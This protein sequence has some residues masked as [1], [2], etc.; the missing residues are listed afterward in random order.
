MHAST[1]MK[2]I[3]GIGLLALVF[4]LSFLTGIGSLHHD[5]KSGVPSAH[6]GFGPPPDLTGPGQDP[7][8][9]PTLTPTAT[10]TP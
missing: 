3:A 9:T 6:A 7:N 1:R 5:G 2:R 10:P 4:A 8:P